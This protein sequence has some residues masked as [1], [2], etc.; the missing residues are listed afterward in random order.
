MTHDSLRTLDALSDPARID[1]AKRSY[2][3][4]LQVIGV[5]NPNLRLVL[6]EF[7]AEVK[8]GDGAEG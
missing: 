1:F 6:R 4:K 3:T 8:A 5:T 2:P 7:K